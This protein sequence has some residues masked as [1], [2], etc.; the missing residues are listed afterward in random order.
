MNMQSQFQPT[1]SF[2]GE[3]GLSQARFGPLSEDHLTTYRRNPSPIADRTFD[4]KYDILRM[5][6]V[7]PASTLEP[8]ILRTQSRTAG[9]G[10]TNDISLAPPSLTADRS[11][12][13]S[14]SMPTGY[15]PG[16]RP[17]LPRSTG[18]GQWWTT[19]HVQTV[20][21]CIG[22]NMEG[23]TIQAQPSIISSI[24]LQHATEREGR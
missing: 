18:S 3:R 10:F 17:L 8:R 21:H 19:K 4:S 12:H 6:Q 16:I 23:G 13:R 24:T 1:L 7:L 14:P 22:R 2:L 15:D 20:Q 11:P 9:T 5:P